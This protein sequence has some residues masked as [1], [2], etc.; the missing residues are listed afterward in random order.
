MKKNDNMTIYF[1]IFLEGFILYWA[2][3]IVFIVPINY[4][5]VLYVSILSVIWSL[6]YLILIIL[7]YKKLIR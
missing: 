7:K 4:L 6:I 3:L 1:W 2:F 5:N